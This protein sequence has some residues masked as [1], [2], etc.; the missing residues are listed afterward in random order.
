VHRQQYQAH[1][2]ATVVAVMDIRPEAAAA[3]AAQSGARAYTDLAAMLAQE[4]LHAVSICTPPG[5]HRDQAI[6]CLEA[7]VA[8]LCEKPLAATVPQAEDIVAAVQRTG[9]LLMTAYCHRYH[10]PIQGAKRLLEEG[11]IGQPLLFHCVFSGR[12]IQ[13]G[14]FRGNKALGGGGCLMDNGSHAVDLFRFLIGEVRHASGRAA[15]VIQNIE[16][17]DVGVALLEADGP[18]YGTIQCSFSTLVGR[19]AVE[20]YGSAGTIQVNYWAGV[21]DLQVRTAG[22]SAWEAVDCPDQPDRFAR[23]IA[24]FLAAAQGRE[25][26]LVTAEDGLRVQRVMDAIYRSAA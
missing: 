5:T 22:D 6:A 25:E 4:E 16:T 26:P 20:I 2:E 12:T 17:D 18:V 11:R 14:L 19:A 10:P 15:T 3:A 1:P 21:P 23:E 13:E 9:V 8:V 24:N 7:G